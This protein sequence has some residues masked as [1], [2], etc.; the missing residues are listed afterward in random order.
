MPSRPAAPASADRVKKSR[1]RQSSDVDVLMA[2]SPR[3]GRALLDHLVRPR[4]QRGRDSQTKG[5]R[6][7][8]VN[9]QLNLHGL[10]DRNVTWLGA[11]E[12]LVDEGRRPAID[13]LKT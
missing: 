8:E 12:D 2:T 4:Q 10:L 6:R 9:H 5:F 13:V 7:L 3:Q 1:R 11:L